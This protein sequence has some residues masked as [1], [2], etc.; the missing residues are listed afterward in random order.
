LSILGSFFKENK[1]TYRVK[2]GKI[3]EWMKSF[4]TVHV[5]PL[6]DI[7]NS[8]CAGP[9]S[10]TLGSVNLFSTH[11][12]R[13]I[14]QK[15]QFG[16]SKSVPQISY[17]KSSN[18]PTTFGI[19]NKFLLLPTKPS[20]IWILSLIPHFFFKNIFVSVSWLYKRASL[21]YFLTHK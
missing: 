8:L 11:Q 18:M 13:K 19:E 17:S 7:F 21:W 3:R 4:W 5:I 16:Y 20:I 15:V 10:T 6:L 1:S 2:W 14:F 12:D 9:P